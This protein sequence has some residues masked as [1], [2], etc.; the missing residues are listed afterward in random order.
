MTRST[1]GTKSLPDKVIA[2]LQ[3]FGGDIRIARQRRGMTQSHLSQ[4]MFV[5]T[6]TIRRVEAGDPGVSFGVY[7]NALFVLGLSDCLSDIAAPENDS[8]AN[9]QQKQKAPKRVR[10]NKVEIDKLDF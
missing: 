9:W 1:L 5:T 10:K 2:L 6:K 8:F 4:N 7:A 3:K